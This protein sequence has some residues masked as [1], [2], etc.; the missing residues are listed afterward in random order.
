MYW[1]I[2][3]IHDQ[4]I[5]FSVKSEIFKKLFC[6]ICDLKVLHDPWRTW[7][8]YRC[9][10][11]CHSTC[12]LY[13]FETQV[14]WKR[15]KVVCGEWFRYMYVIWSLLLSV[16]QFLL[17]SHATLWASEIIIKKE[18]HTCLFCDIWGKQYYFWYPWSVVIHHFSIREPCQGPSPLQPYKV[19]SDQFRSITQLVE[20]QWLNG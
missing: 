15:I 4:L 14:L 8:F 19:E 16:S 7:N 9:L 6:V 1:G 11:F 20:V 17:S 13:D 5:L 2:L 3:L 12:I 10:W 18:Y